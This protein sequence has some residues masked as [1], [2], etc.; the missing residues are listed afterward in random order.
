MA[1]ARAITALTFARI[2]NRR[3]RARAVG[4]AVAPGSA[5]PPSGYAQLELPA[6]FVWSE[7]DELA[8]SQ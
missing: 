4:N 5:I 7:A 2:H 3:A 8:A 1:A 6:G